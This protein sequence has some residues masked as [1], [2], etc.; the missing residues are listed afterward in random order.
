MPEVL[1]RA[2]TLLKW[3]PACAGMTN[4]AIIIM[5]LC[6]KLENIFVVGFL[7]LKF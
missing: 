6:I 4:N 3:I 1:N 5:T 2:S 7:A